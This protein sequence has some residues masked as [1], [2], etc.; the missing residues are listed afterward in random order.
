MAQKDLEDVD[1]AQETIAIPDERL[2]E[3]A[4]HISQDQG[5]QQLVTTIK[6]GWP[7]EKKDV[8]SLLVNVFFHSR[9]TS[10]TETD[11]FSRCKMHRSWKD[12]EDKFGEAPQS[13][14]RCE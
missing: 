1:A 10:R 5:L 3:I 14:S 12:E 11:C 13:P 2:K 9:R 7:T 8:Q 6:N 4:D